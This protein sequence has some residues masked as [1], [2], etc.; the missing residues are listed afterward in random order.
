MANE[1]HVALL[2]QGVKAWNTWR[3]ENRTVHPDRTWADLTGVRSIGTLR[4][5]LDGLQTAIQLKLAMWFCWPGLRLVQSRDTL[6]DLYRLHGSREYVL[7]LNTSVTREG[8]AATWR[9]LEITRCS[10]CACLRGV[11]Q[12][13]SRASRHGDGLQRQAARS[14]PA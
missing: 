2:K 9:A 13:S 1:E 11:V 4:L 12:Q 14:Q 7:R 10:P 6:S 5:S 8:Y 3:R